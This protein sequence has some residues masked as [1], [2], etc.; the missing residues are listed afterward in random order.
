MPDRQ[1]AVVR[2]AIR[3]E[4]SDDATT[5]AQEQEAGGEDPSPGSP[6]VE[7]Q[8]VFL[9]FDDPVLEDVSFSANQGETFA[10]V[11]ESGTGKSTILKLILR[12]LVPE[13]DACSSTGTTSP[14]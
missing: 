7:L 5:D 4:L 8:H 9:A 2:K 3:S 1:S 14:R 13:R 12:L 11:G 6:R 10:I